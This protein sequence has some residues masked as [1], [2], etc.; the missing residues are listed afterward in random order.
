MPHADVSQRFGMRHEL[1][2]KVFR[3]SRG[4]CLVEF[5]DEQMPYAVV[6]NQSDLWLRSRKQMRCVVGPEHFNRMPIETNNDWTPMCRS[7]V[8]GRGGNDGMMT[9]VEAAENPD[10]EKKGTGQ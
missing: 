9:A 7:G 8:L 10:G 3:R 5:D 2:H 1:F 6:A 4:K